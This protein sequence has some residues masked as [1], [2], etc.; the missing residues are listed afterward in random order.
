MAVDEDGVIWQIVPSVD[1]EGEVDHCLVAFVFG[2]LES[3]RRVGIIDIVGKGFPA[4]TVG[5]FVG[6]AGKKAF[7]YPLPILS[8]HEVFS[9]ARAAAT[10]A[11]EIC[12]SGFGDL[13]PGVRR[14][15][16]RP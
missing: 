13:E 15:K 9:V 7:I 3:G 4:V 6:I 2:Y 10:M 11:F 16:G 1:D 5:K 8:I 12:F 14:C